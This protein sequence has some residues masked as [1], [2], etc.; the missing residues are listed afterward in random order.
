MSRST[1]TQPLGTDAPGAAGDDDPA[2]SAGPAICPECKLTV[3]PS[4]PAPCGCRLG[5]SAPEALRTPRTPIDP[6][7]VDTLTRLGMDRCNQAYW[8]VVG[9]VRA[10]QQ[11]FTQ[12][13]NEKIADA[14]KAAQEAHKATGELVEA[15]K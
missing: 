3:I 13:R 11:G 2:A 8:F 4:A 14:L 9:A 1:N 7:R 15:L 10:Q 6:R 5:L 12:S